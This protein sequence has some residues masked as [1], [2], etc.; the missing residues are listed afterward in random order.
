MQH[1]PQPSASPSA[2]PAPSPTRKPP[3]S[4]SRWQ[5]VLDRDDRAD[6]AFLYA[7]ST[8]GIYCRPSCPS[9]RPRRE[10]VSFFDDAEAAERAGFR[11]CKRCHPHRPAGPRP[12][13]LQRACELLAE[14]DS[15]DIATIA[16]AVGWSAAHLQRTFKAALGVTPHQYRRRQRAERARSA[17]AGGTSV[18]DAAYEA[19][20]GSSSRF[21]DGA[22]VELGMPPAKARAGGDGERIAFAIAPSSLGR[23]L[24]AWTPRGV[25][26][27]A[28]DDDERG[29]L[30]R[31][32]TTYPRASLLEA[33]AADWVAS[34]V[35]AVEGHPTAGVPLDVRG[36][37]FQERVW[38]L[39][40]AIPRGQTRS[41]SE[42]ASALGAPT[43]CR[44]VAQA[45]AANP[46]AV[47]VP[48]HRVVRADGSLGGYAWGAERKA[49]LLAGERDEAP[50]LSR[51]SEGST[52]PRSPRGRGASRR[53]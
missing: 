39:L 30:E 18:T 29:L 42:V 44:A 45:C 28:L 9:R 46:V 53:S 24:V 51:R 47:L 48:C 1:P 26:L 17:L 16:R 2:T 4:A 49:R 33:D 7:V 36:T 50:P 6:G 13:A 25:C 10:H 8:T 21:Y 41:Y 3:M 34:V 12:A 14:D 11:P 31:L 19:G 40:R 20:Y 38:Q 35:E 5:S 22:A 15:P 43:A 52:P 37:A 27:V 32:R 23:V